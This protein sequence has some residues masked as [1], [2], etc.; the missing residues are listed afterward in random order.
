MEKQETKWLPCKL[1]E[2]EKQIKAVELAKAMKTHSDLEEEKKASAASFAAQ[3]KDSS[4]KLKYL[5]SVV[6]SGTEKREV[7]V[8]KR[9]Y[10][11]QGLVKYFRE[12]NAEYVDYREMT[13][14]E[15][16]LH[17]FERD[18][19]AEREENRNR[20]KISVRLEKVSADSIKEPEAVIIPEPETPEEIAEPSDE[21]INEVLEELAENEKGENDDTA[22]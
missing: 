22:N 4:A 5:A 2:E 7:P 18:E 8:F 16:Q 14:K 21:E 10:S 6:E 13:E 9:Y 11:A 17:L 20:G 3:L 12:D 19:F 15:R 1:T